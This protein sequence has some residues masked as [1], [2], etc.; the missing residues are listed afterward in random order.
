M[1]FEYLFSNIVNYIEIGA[2]H[3]G[4][5]FLF[6]ISIIEAVPL[7]G[8][9]VPGHTA[10]IISGF[11]ARIGIFNIW[12]V[13]IL[14]SLGA[15]IGDMIGFHLGKKY[16]M[17]LID[18]FKSR[19]F[20]SEKHIEK[21]RSLINKHTGKALIIGRFNPLTRPLMPFIVG[22]SHVRTGT[23]WIYNIIGGILWATSSVMIGYIFGSGYRAAA[24][25]AGKGI[26][27]AILATLLIIW[28][29]RFVNMRFHIFRRYELFALILNILSFWALAKTMEDAWAVQSFMA[30][31]D[32]WVNQFMASLTINIMPIEGTI[33]GFVSAIGGTKAVIAAGTLIS[34]IFILRKRWRSAVIMIL[35]IGSTGFIIEL[36]KTF[37]MR[38]R[39]EN[40]LQILNDY[41]FPSGHAALAAAFFIVIAYLFTPKIHSWVKRELFIVI[42]VLVIILIGVSRIVLNVHWV[43]DVI[44]GWSLGIFCATAT[45]LL[46]RYVGALVTRKGL[47]EI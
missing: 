15:I 25:Y 11:L 43:S 29:Y 39:P 4:Y 16:G 18:R 47:K 14:A 20:I 22:T 13:I 1:P 30:Q 12:I 9:T 7:I 8:A 34:V 41:S 28:G 19:F 37:F 24:Q 21:T 5:V 3:G 44:A 42:C 2:T 35:S 33:A 27:V 26:V 32:I 17:S 36:M 31:F 38:A 45:I 40:A 10:V 23:F 6:L 46:V